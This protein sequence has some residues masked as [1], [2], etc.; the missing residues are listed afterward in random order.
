MVQELFS[1]QRLKAVQHRIEYAIVLLLLLFVRFISLK[2]MSKFAG[3]FGRNVGLYHRRFTKVSAI[4]LA[5]AFPGITQDRVIEIQKGMYDNFM[6]TFVEYFYLDRLDNNTDFTFEVKNEHLIEEIKEPGKAVIFFS[7]HLGNWEIG[8]WYTSRHGYPLVPVY[9]HAN[10]PFVDQIIKNCRRS[11]SDGLIAKG[12][13]AGRESLHALKKGKKLV[14]LVD[15]KMNE[16]L[17][18]PF[19]GYPAPTAHGVV[20]LARAAECPIVP[21]RVI[22]QGALHF[23]IEFFQPITFTE[24]STKSDLDVLM[25]VNQQLEAWIKEYPEQWFWL[26]KRWPKE[27]YKF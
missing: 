26:H 3:W 27:D 19:F 2:R 10:N 24:Y 5:R 6:R 14:M 23:I 25:M 20:R 4:N 8:A 17:D 21:T 7:G 13:R 12:P 15:Q 18:V 9:R 1:K 16:G 22:R 11:I